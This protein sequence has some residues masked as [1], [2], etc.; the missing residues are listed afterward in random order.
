MQDDHNPAAEQ[1][2]PGPA[3][4]VIK[5]N[6]FGIGSKAVILMGLTVGVVSVLTAVPVPAMSSSVS[7]P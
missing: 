5:R 7:T 6:R 3:G 4:E 1:A 2:E